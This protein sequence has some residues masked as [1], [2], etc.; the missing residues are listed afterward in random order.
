MAAD[1]A[2]RPSRQSWANIGSMAGIVDNDIDPVML[3]R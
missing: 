2:Q 1:W 3:A